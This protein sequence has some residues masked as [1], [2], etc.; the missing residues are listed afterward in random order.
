MLPIRPVVNRMMAAAVVI[1][2]LNLLVYLL[3]G[4]STLDVLLALF[5]IY[6][7]PSLTHWYLTISLAG[8]G[9]LAGIAGGSGFSPQKRF[10]RIMML[11]FLLL[12]LDTM[13]RL[14]DS[15]FYLLT[16]Q[17]DI[18]IPLNY[19]EAL[20]GFIVLAILLASFRWLRGLP[21]AVRR[22]FLEGWALY[23]FAA[24]VL[25]VIR[26]L[27]GQSG[28]AT[29]AILALL[30]IIQH[31]IAMIGM[32]SLVRGLLRQIALSIQQKNA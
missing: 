23:L 32:A 9:I 30:L 20:P 27:Y 26:V 11:V 5:D 14:R 25:V 6:N 22:P 19:A 21:L 17:L 7:N 4:G 1:T 3:T 29:T 2:V 15:L 18:S 13:T 31:C 16:V 12:S 10:W 24:V 28:A 8:C